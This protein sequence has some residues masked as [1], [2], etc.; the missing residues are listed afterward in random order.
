MST[1]RVDRLRA[2]AAEFLGSALL[3]AVVVGS[4]AAAQTLTSDVAVA[5]LINAVATVLGLGV[6][7]VLFI[8]ISGAHFNPVVTLVDVAL[9]RRPARIILSYLPA[10]V[11]G[12]IAG[13][14]LANLMFERPALEL[15]ITDRATTAHLLGEVVATAG[16][17]LVIFTLVRLD[18]VAAIPAAVA[19]YI[20]AAYFFTSST[21]FANPAITI[22]RMFTQTF[23]GIAPASV[24][25]FIAAQLGGGA[26]GALAA[27]GIAARSRG[28]STSESKS[29]A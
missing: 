19:A 29:G 21:S 13:T 16:L 24:P 8:T 14:A 22:G 26:L 12:C 28:A 20:G 2:V 10:Q 5:L 4:G 7:I 11:L 17:V 3:G 27:V 9:G 6:L 23:A 15:G 18:K 25:W 1:P